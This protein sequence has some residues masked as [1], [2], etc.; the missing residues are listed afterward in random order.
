[1]VAPESVGEAQNAIAGAD[2]SSACATRDSVTSRPDQRVRSMERWRHASPGGT[3]SLS[4][5]ACSEPSW[6]WMLIVAVAGGLVG[7]LFLDAAQWPTAAQWAYVPVAFCSILYLGYV[8]FRSLGLL[9][10][11]FRH[12]FPWRF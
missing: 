8:L 5:V 2:S 12:R 7:F 3:D 10:R 9:F 1:M 11:H 4:T 6:T